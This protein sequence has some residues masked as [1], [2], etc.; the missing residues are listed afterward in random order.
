MDTVKDI[1]HPEGIKKQKKDEDGCIDGLGHDGAF[2][3]GGSGDLVVDVDDIEHIMEP[4]QEDDKQDNLEKHEVKMAHKPFGRQ[5]IPIPDFG[6]EIFIGH[7]SLL[8]GILTNSMLKAININT[9]SLQS[10]VWGPFCV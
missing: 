2:Q 10:P 5:I 4:E 7:R 6:H 1:Q 3:D 9:F 8:K